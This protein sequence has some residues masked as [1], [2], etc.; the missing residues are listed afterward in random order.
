MA[1]IIKGACPHCGKLLEVPAELEEFSCMYCGERMPIAA[2]YAKTAHE[3]CSAEDRQYLRE[4]LAAAALNYPDYYQKLEKKEFFTAFETY[5]TENT[6]VF[7]RLEACAPED[8]RARELWLRE[9]CGE[10]LDDIAA[11][12]QRDKRWDKGYRRGEVFFE[13]KVVL[14][15]FLTPAMKK[16]SL[17]IAEPFAQTLHALWLERYPKEQWT[18]GDYD[19]LAGG[20]KKFKFCFVT[21]ATCLHEGK[22]D[23][24]AELTAFRAFR[25]GW[26][27]AQPQ[28]ERLI[29]EYYDL[30]P[31][32]VSCVEYCD[33]SAACYAEI[34][35]R[36]L[37]PCYRAL[38][39][40]RP[41]D[42]LTQYSDMISC[43]RSRYLS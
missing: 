39:E 10:L 17:S 26:L 12:M 9:I 11:H 37:A 25:D 16:L 30:A 32:I 40:D 4:K 2:L 27:R 8:A 34:R 6:A 33:D 29:R 35:E 28:G 20:F 43:L 21:T 1:E 15:I 42:C 3:G 22:P 13:H 19:T 18:P 24:C 5:E 41:E 23:D 36:W 38:Q 14:A 7:E 31:A